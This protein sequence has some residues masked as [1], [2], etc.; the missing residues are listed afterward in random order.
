[1]LAVASAFGLDAS[2][3]NFSHHATATQLASN[4]WFEF[5]S[6]FRNNEIDY[7]RFYRTLPRTQAA[8]LSREMANATG[9]DRFVAE[10]ALPIEREVQAYR[11]ERRLNVVLISVESLSADFMDTFGNGKHL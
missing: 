2:W 3:K 5:V 6:A 8:R 4:G 10:S 7:E 11:P 1:V 9:S